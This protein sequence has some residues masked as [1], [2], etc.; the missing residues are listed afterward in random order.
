MTDDQTFLKKNSVFYQD[1]FFL[2]PSK[3]EMR[4]Y[5]FYSIFASADEKLTLIS[6]WFGNK[7]NVF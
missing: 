3:G 7:V 2:F 1:V 4:C 6:Q 5:V